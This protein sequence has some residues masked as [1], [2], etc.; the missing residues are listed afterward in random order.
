MRSFLR[1]LLPCAVVFLGLS[2]LAVF[3]DPIVQPVSVTASSELQPGPDYGVQ[4]LIDQ[5]GLQAGY[6]S[7]VTDF[8]TFTAAT[9]HWDGTAGR[10]F[11]AAASTVRVDFDLGSPMLVTQ[12][13]IWPDYDNQNNF[14]NFD[15]H[16]A[17]DPS[18][19]A[20]SFLG[21]YQLRYEDAVVTPQPAVV[22]DISDGS[23]RYVRLDVKDT[24]LGGAYA[25]ACEVAFAAVPE[26]SV[27]VLWALGLGFLALARRGMHT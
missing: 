22:F 12:V 23:G 16:V 27:G 11:M 6:T 4:N 15:V 26:P 9:R 13:A 24:V 19:A 8:A 1:V 25:L 7:G 21:S 20:S 10:I 18:F 5:V 2:G 3:G 14:G 17:N